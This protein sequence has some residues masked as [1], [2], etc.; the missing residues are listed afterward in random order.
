MEL[1]FPRKTSR[2][3]G[4]ETFTLEPYGNEG[5]GRLL[6]QPN[7]GVTEIRVYL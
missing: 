3:E 5:G 6:A 4:V 2:V 7:T 1:Y